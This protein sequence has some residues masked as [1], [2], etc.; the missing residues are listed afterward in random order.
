MNPSFRDKF[1]GALCD[2]L[3]QNAA[4]MAQEWR[5]ELDPIAA[6]GFKLM[7]IIELRDIGTTSN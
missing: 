6:A 4:L 2:T 1:K 5:F 3:S 7:I